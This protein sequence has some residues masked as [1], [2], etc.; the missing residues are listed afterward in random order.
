MIRWTVCSARGIVPLAV[1]RTHSQ[2]SPVHQCTAAY[3]GVHSRM[4]THCGSCREA[5]RSRGRALPS[6]R[7]FLTSQTLHHHASESTPACFGLSRSG[8]TRPC[9]RALGVLSPI[10]NVGSPSASTRDCGGA[11]YFEAAG[12]PSGVS[13]RGPGDTFADHEVVRSA[14]DDGSVTSGGRDVSS[15]GLAVAAGLLVE[16]FF[17]ANDGRSPRKMRSPSF[18][19]GCTV[20]HM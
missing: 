7:E 18:V 12:D 20:G 14:N 4:T 17:G 10:S 1:Q 9:L 5:S 11:R 2:H 8:D 15:W 16:P 19:M 13:A 3:T 6:S